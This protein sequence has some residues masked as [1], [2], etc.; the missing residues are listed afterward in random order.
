MPVLEGMLRVTVTIMVDLLVVTETE[1]AVP[2]SGSWSD[3]V[4]LMTVVYVEVVYEGQ[5]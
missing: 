3:T 4:V 5:P 2:V 1:D